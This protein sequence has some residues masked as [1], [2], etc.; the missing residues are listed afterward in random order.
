LWFGRLYGITIPDGLDVVDINILLE[1][2]GSICLD[3]R[4]RF[5]AKVLLDGGIRQGIGNILMGHEGLLYV[6]RK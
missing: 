2:Y 5:G 4:I 3:G 1:Q 6:K